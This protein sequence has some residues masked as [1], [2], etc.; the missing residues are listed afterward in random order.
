MARDPQSGPS[1][2]TVA[3]RRGNAS[4][5]L[6][7]RDRTWFCR[8]G[9]TRSQLGEIERGFF[10]R[11]G[12]QRISIPGYTHAK[13]RIW[14]KYRRAECYLTRCGALMNPSA[15]LTSLRRP[16]LGGYFDP[17]CCA[18]RPGG[19]G[20][21]VLESVG[22]TIESSGPLC[23]GRRLLRDSSMVKSGHPH[24][25]EVIGFRGRECCWSMPRRD[26]RR[27]FVSATSGDL[28]WA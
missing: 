11:A 12:N 28:P 24:L 20:G 19:G 3:A 18:P 5:R 2:P 1:S 13:Q 21:S 14:T 17:A 22:Q 6:R 4:R 25:A 27:E 16:L 7:D 26:R 9:R 15:R 10:D 8:P 23:I